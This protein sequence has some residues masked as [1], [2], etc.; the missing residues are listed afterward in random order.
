MIKKKISEMLHG[1]IKICKFKDIQNKDNK[2]Y[3]I[4]LKSNKSQGTN[5]YFLKDVRIVLSGNTCFSVLKGNQL[6]QIHICLY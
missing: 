4:N 2:V 5:L 3:K 6:I 1:K